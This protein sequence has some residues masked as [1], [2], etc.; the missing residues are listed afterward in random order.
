MCGL[1]CHKQSEG[2]ELKNIFILQYKEFTFL[3]QIAFLFT[4]KAV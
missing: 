2:L 1:F 4:E 3:Q